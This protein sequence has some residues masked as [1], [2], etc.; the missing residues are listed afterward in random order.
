MRRPRGPESV[1]RRLVV[2]TGSLSAVLAIGLVVVV[3]VVLTGAATDAVDRVL[4]DRADAVV[5]STRASSG[6]VPEVPAAVLDPGVAVYDSTGGR[7]AGFVPPS[8]RHAFDELSTS[9]T[10]RSVR[11]E[12]DYTV[13][14]RPFAVGSGS[15][16]VDGV[17]VLA[18]P[19][20]PYERDA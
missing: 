13:M 18:E 4:A 9:S 11:V 12:D 5:S 6:S 20:A 14:A 15:D 8:L 2:L 3:E 10:E 19:L 1:R 16:R 17:V 7:V